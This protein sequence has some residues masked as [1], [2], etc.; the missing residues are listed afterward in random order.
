MIAEVY[1]PPRV[2]EAAVKMGYEPGGSYDLLTGWDL[3]N[4]G[5]AKKMW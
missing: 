2:V 3:G 5:H 4:P 1:S